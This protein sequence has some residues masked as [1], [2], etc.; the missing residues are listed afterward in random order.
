MNIFVYSTVAWICALYHPDKHVVKQLLEYCQLLSTA[1]RVL[2]GTQATELTKTGRR[3]K[4]W[5]LADAKADALVYSATHVNHPCAVWVRKSKANYD[6]LAQLLV[7]VTKEYTFRYDK[8]HKCQLIGLVDFLVSNA[9]A[10]IPAGERTPFA[11]A[12]PD[13]CKCSGDAVGSYHTYFNQKKQKLAAWK[14]RTTPDWF[15]AAADT[16]AGP[17]NNL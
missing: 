3:V 10:N 5:R 9:P 4:W 16:A 11:L 1:H 17:G 6:W 14:K 13:E 7:E 8:T 2:D 12:M 15:V